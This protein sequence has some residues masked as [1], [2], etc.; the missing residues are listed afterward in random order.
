MDRSHRVGHPMRYR[1]QLLR[2]QGRACVDLHPLELSSP[3]NSISSLGDAIM[4]STIE[5]WQLGQNLTC[6]GAA[7]EQDRLIID[8]NTNVYTSVTFHMT[9]IDYHAQTIE[10]PVECSAKELAGAARQTPP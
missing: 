7:F 5:A 3:Q 10:S 2:K 6:M 8:A 9:A 4:Q 1:N